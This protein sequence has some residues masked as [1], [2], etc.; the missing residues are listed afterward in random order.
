MDKSNLYLRMHIIWKTHFNV[1]IELKYGKT[2]NSLQEL[3]RVRKTCLLYLVC[4][5]AVFSCT[6]RETA[7]Q[8][9]NQWVFSG[10]VQSQ[11]QW[12]G[13]FMGA[14]ATEKPQESE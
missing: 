11:D 3:M 12:G 7:V 2:L 8:L 13:L 10:E 14:H 5:I 1:T 9:D 4:Y 6:D